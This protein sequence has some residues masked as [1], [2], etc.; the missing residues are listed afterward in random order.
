[1]SDTKELEQADQQKRIHLCVD[2]DGTLLKGDLLVENLIKAFKYKPLLIFKAI[3]VAIAANKI[4]EDAKA[5]FKNTLALGCKIDSEN[6]IFNQSVLDFINIQKSKGRKIYLVTASHEYL[7]RQV[8]EYLNIFDGLIASDLSLNVKGSVKAEI[9]VNRFAD[10]GFDYIGNE[11]SDLAVWQVARKSYAVDCPREVFLEANERGI[12]LEELVPHVTIADN[13]PQ[14]LKSLRPHQWVKNLLIFVPAFMGHVLFSPLILLQSVLAFIVFCCSASAVYQINDL[15]DS[16]AD[17]K[18][19][20]KSKRPIAAGQISPQVVIKVI[21]T[22]LLSALIISLFLPFSFFAC[23]IAY[24]IST[25][26]YSIYF[27]RVIILDIVTLAFLYAL[28]VLSGAAATSVI[29][30]P[31]L[32]AFSL[33]IFYSL[34][35]VKR[36]SE[37]LEKID[38]QLTDVKTTKLA[39]RGYH[40]KDIAVIPNLGISSGLLSVLVLALYINSDEVQALY[41][42]PNFL[43]LLTLPLLYWISRL[44]ILASRGLVD[45]DPIVFALKDRVSYYLALFIF[46]VL[47][48][49][50]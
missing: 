10:R 46:I 25:S 7:A 33:F 16:G 19:P 49:A 2:L 31:W 30:S 43:W 1:M 22:L 45:Q 28:R 27:K 38:N 26:A 32:L 47:F 5:A 39:G 44:W 21:Y 23:F 11:K 13:L 37:L 17:R 3:Y 41:I 35:C 34:A 36:Y 40:L 9:L 8:F 18:H 20:T 12:V 15:L 42:R 6:L 50:H 29:V 24:L 48:I 4:K 14:I